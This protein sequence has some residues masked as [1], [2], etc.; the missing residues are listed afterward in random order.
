V[1]CA[2][3]PGNILHD[4][5]RALCRLREACSKMAVRLFECRLLVILIF[6]HGSLQ[7]AH[8][9][10]HKEKHY[11][12]ILDV[13]K[14]VTGA[15]PPFTVE[16]PPLWF[17]SSFQ[18]S[19]NSHLPEPYHHLRPTLI[20]WDPVSQR[21]LQNR[22]VICPRCDV[23]GVFLRPTH[24]KDGRNER[25]VPRLLFACN[26]VTYLVSK[27]YRC[28]NGHE[29][30]AHYNSILQSFP[31][32]EQLPFLLSHISGITKDLHDDI[33]L[34]S[35]TGMKI[36][37]IECLIAQQHLQ[38]FE[39]RREMF[40]NEMKCCQG[41]QINSNG[42]T[43]SH[44]PKSMPDELKALSNDFISQCIIYDYNKK[45]MLYTQCMAQTSAATS[46]SRDHT[47]KVAANIGLLRQS[48]QKWEKRYDAM[49]CILNEDGIGLS[50]QLTKGTAFDKVRDLNNL[51]GRFDQQNNMVKL[52]TINNC[53]A[54]RG[55]LQ[56]FLGSECSL[57]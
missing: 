5:M 31:S 20:L 44:F 34:Y 56:D 8:C 21:T 50:W 57:N 9:V 48:D 7:I 27:V 12:Y 32:K 29:I 19:L 30:V 51:K 45:E 37:Q 1:L 3:H 15:I 39:K 33:V 35:T 2:F 41:E 40:D 54:W 14:E 22:L 16:P 17:R 18:S 53:C 11:R 46:I 47:F 13:L 52:C 43:N 36:E 4:A 28:C 26:G 42:S 23:A 25:N 6:F 55:K 24:W 38:Y 10:S 49:F